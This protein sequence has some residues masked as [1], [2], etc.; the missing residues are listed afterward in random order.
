MISSMTAFGQA[1]GQTLDRDITIEIR[2]VN[3]RFCDI[4]H[5]IPKQYASLEGQIKKQVNNRISRGR[6]EVRIRVDET[7]AVAQSLTINKELAFIYKALYSDLKETL[8]LTGEIEFSHLLSV[9]DIIVREEEQIDLDDFL[10]GLGP[11]LEEALDNLVAM[12]TT[13]GQALATDYLDRM[14]E[15][16]GW[17]E[18]IE[19]RR[20]T[21]RVESRERLEERIREL[22]QGLELD[23]ARLSQEAAHI[24]DRSDITEEIVR[25]RSHFDQSRACV[26]K[27]GVAGRRLEFLL[28][29]INRE[30]NTIGSK[31]GDTDITKVVIDLKSELEKLREQVQNIE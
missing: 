5:H 16:S 30:V 29:E 26:E 13:E 6:I 25:L 7:A 4:V 18:L 2:S 19:S 27:G 31:S 20:E 14:R 9:K 3:N 23:Q 24:A 28:Q 15:M 10:A 21:V 8:N 1:K 11:I 22:T 17:V 12:R